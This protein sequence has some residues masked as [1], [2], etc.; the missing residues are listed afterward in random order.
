MPL[1]YNQPRF[2][3]AVL[4]SSRS[5]LKHKTYKNSLTGTLP[6]STYSQNHALALRAMR[7]TTRAKAKRYA[8]YCLFKNGKI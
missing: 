6:D 4:T 2:T 1:S 7:R 5:S 8:Y 3:A